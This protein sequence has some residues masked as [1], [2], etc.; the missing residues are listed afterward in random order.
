MKLIILLLLAISCYGQSAVYNDFSPTVKG[1]TVGTYH[2]NFFFHSSVYASNS[3]WDYEV[4]CY[5]GLDNRVL[6]F[7]KPGDNLDSG[8][9]FTGGYIRYIIKANVIDPTKYDFTLSGKGPSDVTD[10]TP[11]KVT[12]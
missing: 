9:T 8:Y 11:I 5:S 2:C 12:L 10:I 1:M 7:K 4:A 3:G 6:E